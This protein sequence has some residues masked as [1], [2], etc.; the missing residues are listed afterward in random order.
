MRGGDVLSDA[1]SSV[2]KGACL[3]ARWEMGGEACLSEPG[4]VLRGDGDVVGQR[5]GAGERVLAEGEG[6]ETRG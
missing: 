3:T 2:S 4:K 1:A 5:L 6:E